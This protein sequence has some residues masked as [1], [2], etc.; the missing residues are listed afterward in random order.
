V[1]TA[2]GVAPLTNAQLGLSGAGWDGQAPLWFYILKEAEKSASGRR[3]GP[4]GGTIV[5]EVL[6]GLL[7][8]DSTSFV[9]A[10]TPWRPVRPIAPSPGK[11]GIANLLRFAGVA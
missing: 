1:A 9:N 5:A 11:F 2:L 7:A 10:E 6:L 3:L 8:E 4:V